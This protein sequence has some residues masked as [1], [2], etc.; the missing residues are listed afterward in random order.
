ML[1]SEMV[2]A[3]SG[4]VIGLGSVV[5][6]VTVARAGRRTPQQERRDDFTV[7]TDELQEQLTAVK[8]DL[9]E[10]RQGRR[11]DSKTIHALVRY[12]RKVLAVQRAHGIAPPD[13]D[14]D[15][16]LELAHHGLP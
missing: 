16:A 9:A 13:P 4:I 5:G 14:P 6:T 1:S 3:I 12:V 2:T 8:E 11:E 15:D 10:Q 7:V